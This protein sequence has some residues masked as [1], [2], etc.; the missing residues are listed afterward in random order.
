MRKKPDG[1]RYKNLQLIDG[2][3][4]Y[5]RQGGDAIKVDT[6]CSTWTEAAEWKRAFEAREPLDRPSRLAAGVVPTF[7]EVAALYIARPLQLG[8]LSPSTL[9]DKRSILRD[10]G[11]L[12]ILLGDRRV[13]E[14]DA[15][16]LAEWW[17]AQIVEAG[18]SRSHGANSINT[19]SL[20]LK[21]A[22]EEGWLDSNPVPQF[23]E[24]LRSALKT[25]AGR[26]GVESKAKPI[27]EPE[28]VAQLVAAAK[29]EG[30]VP[31]VFTLLLL[32]TGMR[33]AEAEALTWGQIAFGTD[34]V[35]T[36]RSITIDRA[37]VLTDY[38]S[39]P[40][41]G[42]SRRVQVSKRLRR[43]L[44]DLRRHR[45]EPGPDARVLDGLTGASF[46][47]RDWRRIRK[48]AGLGSVSPKDLRDTF[49]SQLLTRGINPAFVAKQL[50]HSNW[51]VTAQHYARWTGGDAYIEPDR[52]NAGEVPADLLGRFRA[53]SADSESANKSDTKD[54]RCAG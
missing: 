22:I 5:R 30:H 51:A 15:D 16:L 50:G 8:E 14:V 12:M 33:M 52:L 41:S 32:D 35:A 18:K 54:L 42:R 3:I 46:R 6:R 47:E 39:P 7:R 10:E 13:D 44:L 36:S 43:G 27:E 9:R 24:R 29:V 45:F 37:R 11:S 28:A 21:R 4:I 17:S 31:Y 49:A 40:K 48:R 25:K 1:S 23:R 20:V 34:E 38:S 26:A 2:K 53:D 19:V